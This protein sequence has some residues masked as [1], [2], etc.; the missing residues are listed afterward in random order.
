MIF[1]ATSSHTLQHLCHQLRRQS[2]P[3]L[4][5]ALA[6]RDQATPALRQR[7]PAAEAEGQPHETRR[8]ADVAGRHARPQQQ[9][10]G[11]EIGPHALLGHTTKDLQA[12][13]QLP[14]RRARVHEVREDVDVGL[15]AVLRRKLLHQLERPVRAF[16]AVRKLHE[17]RERERA[18]FHACVLHLL[19]QLHA[20][21]VHA[22]L[23]TAVDERVVCYFVGTE[24]VRLL[25]RLQQV[26][27]LVHT[28]LLAIALEDGTVGDK[29]WLYLLLRH[30]I[31]EGLHTAHVSSTRTRI[32]E[33]IVCDNGERELSLHH[34]FVDHPHPIK[35]LQVC[36]ALENRAVD[37][38]VEQRL[39]LLIS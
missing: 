13:V 21:V 37:D 6:A 32:N 24:L 31:Q 39:S 36:E 3:Q 18:G 27:G 2:V 34:L 20:L 33:G 4:Q 9:G 17:D 19:Q 16:A 8:A 29:V 1:I 28:P 15:Q 12:L 7:R 10:V 25:H 5:A 14:V 38:Y 26:K 22:A 23:G 30:T 11:P 35:H